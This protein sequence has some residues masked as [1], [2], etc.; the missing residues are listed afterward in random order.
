LTAEAQR[1]RTEGLDKRTAV[2]QLEYAGYPAKA[3]WAAAHQVWPKA[4]TT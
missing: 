4:M 2:R 3:A 1:L